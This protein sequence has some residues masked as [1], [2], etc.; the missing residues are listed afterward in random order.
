MYFRI[1][2]HSSSLQW[3]L[4][5]L[6][7]H[8]FFQFSHLQIQSYSFISPQSLIALQALSPLAIFLFIKVIFQ[9]LFRSSPDALVHHRAGLA[10]SHT[11]DHFHHPEKIPRECSLCELVEKC[12][13]TC[14]TNCLCK[15]ISFYTSVETHNIP[16]L[17]GFV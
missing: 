12:F 4:S 2:Y 13:I 15:L 6:V 10:K 3:P 1:K 7:F 8:F 16:S 9:A 14:V 11:N 17:L 5:F